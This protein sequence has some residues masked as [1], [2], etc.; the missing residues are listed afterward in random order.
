MKNCTVYNIPRNFGKT[1][2]TN[3]LVKKEE[4]AIKLDVYSRSDREAYDRVMQDMFEVEL[5]LRELGIG[6]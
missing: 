5:D 3:L 6:G 4:L 2:I 1:V